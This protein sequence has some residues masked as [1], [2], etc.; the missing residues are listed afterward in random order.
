MFLTIGMVF[1]V[2][3]INLSILDRISYSALNFLSTST[4]TIVEP[5]PKLKGDYK[6]KFYSWV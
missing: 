4:Y 1:A 3:Y 5:A 6:R 2:I